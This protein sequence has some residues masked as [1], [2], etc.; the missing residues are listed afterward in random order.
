VVATDDM[1]AAYEEFGSRVL[2]STDGIEWMLLDDAATGLEGVGLTDVQF[3]DGRYLAVGESCPFGEEHHGIRAVYTSDNGL[4]FELI[5]GTEFEESVY[6]GA[7][8]EHDGSLLLRG[9]EF[10]AD[11]YQIPALWMSVD[12]TAWERIPVPAPAEPGDSWVAELLSTDEA[13]FIVVAKHD[14]GETGRLAA[15]TMAED[16]ALEPV[17]AQAGTFE[18]LADGVTGAVFDGRLTNLGQEVCS[19]ECDRRGRSTS[20]PG[21]PSEARHQIGAGSRL[22]PVMCHPS[23]AASRSRSFRTRRRILPDADL[24]ISSTRSR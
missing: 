19:L 2:F 1:T 21:R 5:A 10:V 23:L 18:Q 9:F 14:G 12:A 13:M 11:G 16:K 20:S 4:R 22:A 6:P 7:L 3:V 17:Q 24:G 8:V 15:D